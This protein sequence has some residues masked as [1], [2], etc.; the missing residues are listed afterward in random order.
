MAAFRDA[1]GD[2]TGVTPQLAGFG[3]DV[4]RAGGLPGE[5]RIVAR[6]IPAYG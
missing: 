5:G 4:V 2:A 6:T 3:L 1:F